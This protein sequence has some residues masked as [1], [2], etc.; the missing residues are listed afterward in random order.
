MQWK[1]KPQLTA[2]RE[3]RSEGDAEDVGQERWEPARKQLMTQDGQR[4]SSSPTQG[5]ANCQ[6]IIY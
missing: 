3:W 1:G 5:R 4:R 6:L 2:D